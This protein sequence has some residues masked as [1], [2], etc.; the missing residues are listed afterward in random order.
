MEVGCE[1]LSDS[2]R[3][4]LLSSLRLRR[5]NGRSACRVV[6]TLCCLTFIKIDHQAATIAELRREA[7]AWKE[8]FLRVE[9]ERSRLSARIEEMVSQRVSVRCFPMFYLP[10]S[11]VSRCLDKQ[12][13][14]LSHRTLNSAFTRSPRYRLFVIHQARNLV[15]Q[16][17]HEGR[18]C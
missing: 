15:R 8:Q 2:F 4:P 6:A 10:F 7:Q 5:Q 16:P 18:F 12:K 9:D 14:D 1:W 17:C 13:A 11:R 3:W